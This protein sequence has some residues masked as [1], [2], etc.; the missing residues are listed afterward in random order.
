MLL[1][2]AAWILTVPP[3]RGIDEIDHAY[4]AAAVAGGQF[5]A[6]ELAENGRGGLVAVPGSIVAA[7]QAQCERLDYTGPDD[8]SPISTLPDG[9][10][11][12][13]SSASSYDPLFYWVV[14]TLARPFEGA[15]ALYAMRIAT[16]LWAMAFIGLAVWAV[17]R[18]AGRWTVAGVLVAVTPVFLYSTTVTA[19]NG[20]E[21]A[22]GLALWSTL[23]A[24]IDGRARTAETRLLA[25]AIASATAL[26]TLR[27]LGPLF[28][29]MI[30][31][32]VVAVNH[33]SVRDLV[34]RRAR[35]MIAG[36]LLVA[37]S[38]AGQA[39]WMF[40]A[41]SADL[42]DGEASNPT[43]LPL[44][45]VVV[46]PMQTIAAFPLRSD[47]GSPVVYPTFL[48]LAGS[49]V[50]LAWRRGAPRVR[51]TM[52]GAV[53]V[54]LAFPFVMTLLTLQSM[55]NIWQGRY[56]L[57][58][59]VG[60]LLLAGYAMDARGLDWIVPRRVLLPAAVLYGIAVA[61][62]LLKVRADELRAT[63]SA[64]DSSWH[65]PWAGLLICLVTLAAVSFVVALQR[66]SGPQARALHSSAAHESGL[67]R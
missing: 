38:V 39:L 35:P 25:G 44:V 27:M 13:A 26:G 40:E 31:A 29:L 5:S 28:I 63:A 34:S 61:A 6:E 8:C 15:D 57:P 23:L 46:W 64:H 54:S 1:L 7:A 3:F 55:G 33:R 32:T 59:A 50:A 42:T 45:N 60:F 9:R 49:L 37:L 4:R 36:C 22:A 52:L 62:C 56:L 43:T 2:Q 30:V 53:L 65:V 67:T 48:L 66:W 19:P 14:G 24:L 12:V 18:F 58:Y 21:M 41:V 10:V 47:A 20:V 16:A 51:M 11:E 17:S